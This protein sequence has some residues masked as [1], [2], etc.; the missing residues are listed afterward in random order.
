MNKTIIS[1]LI[2][3]LFVIFTCTYQKTS[4]IYA[5]KHP[6][7][8]T[9]QITIQIHNIKKEEKK[10]E[11]TKKAVIKVEEIIEENKTFKKKE[12]T[13]EEIT[14]IIEVKTP[15]KT[16]E[17]K[18]KKV[19]K[20]TDK[21]I[22]EDVKVLDALLLA[23]SQRDIAL[24]NRKE[25][26]LELKTL[27]QDALDNRFTVIVNRNKDEINLENIQKELLK[28]RETLLDKVYKEAEETAK[29]TYKVGE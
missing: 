5:L 10:K 16:K 25:F 27:L 12:K 14:K 15:Q 4:S 23:L 24:E 7:I 18:T 3:L 6:I 20:K 9:Q 26:L 28:L 17:I 1:L 8:S 13:K 11:I 21:K 19:N 2:L 22:L 29:N